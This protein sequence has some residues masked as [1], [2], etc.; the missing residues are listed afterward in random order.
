MAGVV[1]SPTAVEDLGEL[2]RTNSLAPTTQE[3]IIRSLRQL[4]DFPLL[5]AELGKHWQGLRFVPGPWHWLII[6][7]AYDE[8]RD[9]V[10]I[11][12]FQDGRAASWGS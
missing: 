7:Y 11:V 6:V 12:T 1:V 2:I 8:E 9:E 4:A 5:G 10:A 3:R